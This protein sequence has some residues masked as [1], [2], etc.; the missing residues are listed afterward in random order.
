MHLGAGRRPLRERPAAAELD[1]VGMRADRERARRRQ[2]RV[3]GRS[4][5]RS[6]RREAASAAR[7]AG[8]STSKPSS[9]SRTTRDREPERAGDRG[10]AAGRAGS[11]GEREAASAGTEST[12]VPSSRWHGT[13]VDDPGAA[14]SRSA[15]A[16]PA[17]RGAGRRGRRSTRAS[18][19]SRCTRDAGGRGA[20][21]RAGSSTTSTPRRRA[22]ARTS[23]SAVTTTT[24]SGAGGGERRGRP[25]RRASS[26]RW[27]ASS[28][29]ARRALPE[30][31]ARIGITTPAS[32]RGTGVGLHGAA[33]ATDRGA[34][35]RWRRGAAVPAAAPRAC[36]GRS[37]ASSTS[38]PTGP[39][40]LACNHISYLDPLALA[41]LGLQR[42]RRIRFLAKAEL[43]EKPVL[44]ALLRGA[45]QIP[46][47]RGHRRRRRRRSVAA[48]DA[49]RAGECVAVFPEGT[50]SLDLDP[51]AGKSGT[52]AARGGDRCAG[53]AGRAVGDAPHHVQGPQAARGAP[54]SPRSSHVGAPLTSTPDEDVREATDRI[55]GAI[56]AQVRRARGLY[57]QHAERAGEGDWWVR[58]PETAVAAE[59]PIARRRRERSATHEGRGDRRRVV[60]HGGGRDRRASTPTGAVGA[61]PGGRGAGRRRAR[62]PRLPPRH[63][64]ARDALHATSDLVGGVHRRRRRGD[65]GAV[66]R[67]P[68]RARRRAAPRSA[69]TCRSSA[70]RRAS[71]RGPCCG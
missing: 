12:G 57:P 64:A 38:R 49:L 30:R 8:T 56:C 70:C 62:E 28:A 11:V 41:Y 13:I 39:V 60:G 43:F 42:K 69:P 15:R 71:S 58:A 6:R 33:Y 10:V 26:A 44:G 36:G 37:R 7:S 23:A 2:R 16:R 55:M 31:N 18:P 45:H 46:V 54:A 61:R 66:A 4:R 65:G 32:A 35:L 34:G 21:E 40:I 67:L 9:G 29:S 51:M 17:G 3:R 52:G 19:W 5:R 68:R 24:G 1:V 63:R 25:S 47:Q 22:H 20:V 48:E 59:L 14:P 53:H 50:I 27:S